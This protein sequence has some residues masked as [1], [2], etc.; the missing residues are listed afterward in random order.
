MDATR[1]RAY[2]YLL[3]AGMLH[4]KWDLACWQGSVPW[5][6]RLVGMQALAANRA[7]ARSFAFHNLAIFAAND[8]AGFEESRFWSGVAK[9]YEEFPECNTMDYREIFER[10]VRGEELAIVSPRGY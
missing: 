6:R 3:A 1:R 7:A 2:E 8:F 10:Y 5:W 9:F 4:V